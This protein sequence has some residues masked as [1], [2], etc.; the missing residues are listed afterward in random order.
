MRKQIILTVF[1]GIACAQAYAQIAPATMSANA[2]R[3]PVTIFGPNSPHMRFIEKADIQQQFMRRDWTPGNVLFRNGM[4][5]NN[6][7]LLFDVHSNKLYFRQGDQAMEFLNPVQEF[8]IGLIVEKDTAGV[9]YRVLYPAV[10]TNTDE[11]FYE[12]LVD[13]KVQ[14]LRCRAKNVNL[15]KDQS[16]PEPKRHTEK[17]QL[18]VYVDGK[19]IKIKKD[20]DDILEAL[21]KLADRINKITSEQRL[22][23]KTDEGL[24]RL[25]R[26]LNR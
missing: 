5:A 2:Y 4:S 11:T 16:Q 1:I 12:V 8:L 25:F 20:K 24:L 18:Y 14:L 22:K 10:N 21:P 13:G 6:V 3:P 23:L 26:E 9:V 7:L 19:M 15:Y 17:E